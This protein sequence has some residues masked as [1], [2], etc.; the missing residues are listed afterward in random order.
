MVDRRLIVM[1]HAKSSWA[2]A[3]ST[4]HARPLNDRG[5]R[6]APHL[7]ALL[8]KRGWQPQ[9]I[10]SS[11]AERTRETADC[12]HKEWNGDVPVEFLRTLYQ[13]GYA[14]LLQVMDIVPDDVQTL[15]VLG[16]NPGWEDVVHALTGESIQLKTATAALLEGTGPTWADAL[17][18]RGQWQAVDVL[19]A[20]E[21]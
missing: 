17:R 4:D 10:V 1:R 16:H 11:D 13:A 19:R 6:D 8:V 21:S 9:F 2:S 12:M 20:R 14:E 3:A 18:L 7:A 5:R 15:L